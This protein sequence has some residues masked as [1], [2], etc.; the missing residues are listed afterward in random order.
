MKV[1]HVLASN[2]YSG[3]ENVVCQI[4]RMFSLND[5]IEMAYTSPSG[6]IKNALDERGINFLPMKELSKKE[7][8]SVIKS[9]QPDIIHAHDMK[10]SFVVMRVK[11]K[12][13]FISHI[14][15]NAYENRRISLKS[16]AYYFAAKKAEKIIWVSQ[17]SYDGYIFHKCF[18]R[19][20]Q[21]LCNIIN[22]DDLALRINED[23]NVYHY[24]VAFL[25]RLTYPKNPQR[26]I[27]VLSQ[28]IQK[29]PELKVAIIGDGDLR[30]EIEDLVK[31]LKLSNNIDFLGFKSNPYKILS[32]SKVM[33]MTSRW[34]GLPMCV[35]EAL[36]LGVPVVSTITDGT[37]RVIVDGESGYLS[38]EDE[39]L[40]TGVLNIL[41][42]NKTQEQASIN[43]KN[44]FY[45][46]NN[47]ETYKKEILNI[48]SKVKSLS[49]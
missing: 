21:V 40:I 5:N 34:E 16:I 26:L 28:V 17:S 25:G 4:V 30:E 42:N 23:K 35:L 43:A 9:Y 20:S 31:E 29:K 49:K 24:D 47:I 22:G 12:I 1:L 36:C 7:L 15:N 48:Y 19:K 45:E 39:G 37:E 46:I 13:P 32:S 10:A 3:A 8:K 27:T 6:D 2:K 33:L 18:T 38:N 14:H 11:K 41:E 44:R